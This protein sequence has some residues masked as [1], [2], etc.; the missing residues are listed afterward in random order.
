MKREERITW[1]LDQAEEM[2]QRTP[3]APDSELIPIANLLPDCL[4]NLAWLY[5]GGDGKERCNDPL[6][7][8]TR[9]HGS[10]RTA[11]G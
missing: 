8:N 2:E 1:L 6:P 4:R 7:R 5:A 3:P 11:R 10:P 9:R